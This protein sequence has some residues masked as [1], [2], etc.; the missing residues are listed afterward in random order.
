MSIG[1]LFHFAQSP[2]YDKIN[3]I[4]PFPLCIISWVQM[5]L[6]VTAMTVPVMSPLNV[7]LR[8]PVEES[9]LFLFLLE[10]CPLLLQA[11]CHIGMWTPGRAPKG[12][13]STQS[14]FITS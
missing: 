1:P 8:L 6:T 12:N 10:L 13:N 3:D 2:F 11:T 9:R 4:L 14:K 7:L 5:M